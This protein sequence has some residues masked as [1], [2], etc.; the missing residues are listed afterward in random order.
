MSFCWVAPQNGDFPLCFSSKPKKQPQ[1][2]THF[3]RLWLVLGWM[4]E[5]R[6]TIL[7]WR[8]YVR[9]CLGNLSLRL[10]IDSLFGQQA[11]AWEGVPAFMLRGPEL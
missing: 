7:A 9:A 11:G 10:P 2:D 8:G 5:E 1:K 4:C 6:A 3:D